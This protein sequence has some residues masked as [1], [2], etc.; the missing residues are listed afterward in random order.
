MPTSGDQL[1]IAQGALT[2]ERIV[3]YGYRGRIIAAASFEAGRRLRFYRH[4]I[5]TGASFPR[6]DRRTDTPQLLDPHSR[7]PTQPATS[8]SSP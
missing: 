8:R 1:I 2:E 5:V 4:Q 3:V 7:T 6:V